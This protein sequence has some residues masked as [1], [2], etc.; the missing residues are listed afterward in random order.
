MK[1]GNIGLTKNV[2]SRIARVW[3]SSGSFSNLASKIVEEAYCRFCDRAIARRLL[4]RFASQRQPEKWVFIVGCYNSG[5]TLLQKVLSAHQ[6]ISGLPREGV[7]FTEG[8]SNLE[9]N[10]HHM[11]WDEAWREHVSPTDEESQQVAAMV[12]RDWSIF[13]VHGC[14]IFLEKSIANT[15]RIEWLNQHFPNAHFIGLH[16]NGYCIAEGLHRRSRPPAWFVEQ[17][18]QSRYPLE[19]AA[20]QWV[21]IN[22]A[23]LQGLSLVDR[24]MTLAFEDFVADPAGNINQVLE[25]LGVAGPAVSISNG[26]LTVGA[27]QFTIHNT[28]TASLERL[29]DRKSLIESIVEPM[30]ARL[31]NVASVNKTVL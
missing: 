2:A 23:M 12:K 16:R 28:N 20:E 21:T 7:R 17:T 26:V 24:K 30:M 13:W 11:F 5:T 6:A 22:T 18:G 19:M 27:Q 31:A 10:D 14:N 25:F 9:L 1:N 8:L 4:S 29:G 15:A 3:R